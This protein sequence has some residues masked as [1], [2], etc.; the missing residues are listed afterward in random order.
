MLGKLFFLYLV[1]VVSA[2]PASDCSWCDA[3]DMT[4][5]SHLD[6]AHDC[7]ENEFYNAKLQR[8]SYCTQFDS[9]VIDLVMRCNK[10]HDHI[11]KCKEHQKYI[12]FEPADECSCRAV[13][14]YCDTCGL[15]NNEFQSFEKRKCGDYTN[16]VCCNKEDDVVVDGTKCVSPNDLTTTT[17]TAAHTH[18]VGDTGLQSGDVNAASKPVRTGIVLMLTFVYSMQNLWTLI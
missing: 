10:T 5:S 4:S 17:T 14:E 15:G 8:C 11:L 18:K 13:C 6:I 2:F 1:C 12:T 7:G 16:T 3:P 9:E